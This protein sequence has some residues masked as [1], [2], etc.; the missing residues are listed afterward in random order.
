MEP[1]EVFL[2]PLP[3]EDLL[4]EGAAGDTVSPLPFF[5]FLE[6][7]DLE[8]GGSVVSPLSPLPPDDFFDSVGGLG[9]SVVSPLPPD[10]F[11]SV[12]AESS[13]LPRVVV[14]VESFLVEPFKC[15]R[16]FTN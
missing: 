4:E 9:G 6:V 16:S 3:D 2:L 12:G 11:D 15:I 8:V 5:D 7:D 14:F 10:D 1:L 13:P